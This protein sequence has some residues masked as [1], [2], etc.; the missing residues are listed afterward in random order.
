MQT[1]RLV[2]FYAKSLAVVGLSGL[3]AIGAAIDHWP[4]PGGFPEVRFAHRWLQT[5]AVRTVTEIPALPPSPVTLQPVMASAEVRPLPLIRSRWTASFHAPAHRPEP[6]ELAA[7]AL[8]VPGT[9]GIPEL[10]TFELAEVPADAP[11]FVETW[12][13][14]PAPAM[15]LARSDDG[16]FA[17][18]LKK[19]GSSVSASIGKARTTIV[20]AMRLVSGAVKRAF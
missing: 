12:Q 4:T 11:V 10:P 17:G 6:V 8:P 1:H 7:V 14:M 5:P 9:I 13:P 20:D 15:T 16:F 3:A 2:D 19:T 18:A